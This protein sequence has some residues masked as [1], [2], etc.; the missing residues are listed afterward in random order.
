LS[1]ARFGES[2][3]EKD[4]AV[5]ADVDGCVF[6][7][8]EHIEKVLSTARAIWQ[9]ERKQATEISAGE[10]LRRQLHLDEYLKKRALNPSLTFRQ[11]LREIGG[12]I[13]E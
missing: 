2:T 8:G 11:H 3:V 10:T 4:D 13:E 6:V 9:T 12:A 7:D 1:V 5:F